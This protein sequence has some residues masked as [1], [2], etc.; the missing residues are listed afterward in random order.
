MVTRRS[1]SAAGPL[2]VGLALPVLVAVL[3]AVL[4]AP[5]PVSAAPAAPGSLA[6]DARWF[7]DAVDAPG[8][9]VAEV[10]PDGVREVAAEGSDGRGAEVTAA[11]PFVWGSVSKP[12]TARVVEKWDDDEVLDP[13]RPAAEVL[14]TFRAPDRSAPNWRPAA[15]RS[16]I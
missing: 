3:V 16:A 10:G 6:A 9:V 7:R 5:A 15:P 8:V 14:P 12:V 1:D 2:V 11:T 4:A 13:D